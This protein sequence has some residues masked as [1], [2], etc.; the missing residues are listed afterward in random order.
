MKRIVRFFQESYAE[1]RKVIWPSTQEVTA[2][3]QVVII[4]VVIIAVFLGMIDVVIYELLN[5]I[6]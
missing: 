4:S 6:F 3:T 2:S 5:L 1:L